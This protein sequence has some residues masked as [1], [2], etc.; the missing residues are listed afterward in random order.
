M[1]RTTIGRLAVTGAVLLGFVV[2]CGDDDD[3]GGEC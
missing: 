1:D 2:A 3:A